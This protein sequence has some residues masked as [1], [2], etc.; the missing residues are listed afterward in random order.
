[1]VSDALGESIGLKFQRRSRTLM[2]QFEQD[3]SLAQSPHEL[4]QSLR[5]AVRKAVEEALPHIDD[6]Q[7]RSEAAWACQKE[8][9][10]HKEKE[11]A[12]LVVRFQEEKSE[13]DNDDH[14]GR[15]S[16]GRC[17]GDI[18]Q[19][20]ADRMA[21]KREKEM[22]GGKRN[23]VTDWGRDGRNRAQDMVVSFKDPWR[24]ASGM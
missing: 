13:P 24:R 8:Q 16:V 18:L 19:K 5:D 10:K 1:M 21:N 17:P 11:R 12:K 3:A 22:K 2:A 4:A 23:T 15:G 7:G 6:V 14:V 20:E 9:W